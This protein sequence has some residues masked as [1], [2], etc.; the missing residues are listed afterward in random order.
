MRKQHFLSRNHGN[1]VPTHYICV[2]TETISSE[3]DSVTVEAKLNFGFA[4]YFQRRESGSYTNL[5][6]YRFDTAS[7]FWHW[8]K[9]KTAKKQR[10]VMF[11]HNWAFDFTVLKGFDH[12]SGKGWKCIKSVIEGPPTIL[13][14]RKRGRTLILLDTLNYFRMPLSS[15]GKAIGLPKTTMPDASASRA[16]WDAY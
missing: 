8:A 9:R 12:T 6:W 11:A 7:K 14:F 3:L 5:D 15:L 1:S 10:V 16:E 13:G 2:D 4:C